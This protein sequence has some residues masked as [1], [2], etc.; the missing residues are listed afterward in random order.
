IGSVLALKTS[1]TVDKFSFTNI[2]LGLNLQAGPVNFYV[3][4][5][6]LLGYQNLASSHYQSFQI[7]LNIISWGK[8]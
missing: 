6:N 5:D 7:G 4:A 3:L 8:K 1:Y 2:G